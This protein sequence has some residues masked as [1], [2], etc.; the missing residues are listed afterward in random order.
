MDDNDVPRQHRA[1]RISPAARGTVAEVTIAE[2]RAPAASVAQELPRPAIRNRELDGIRGWAAIA[3]IAQHL[4]RDIFVGAFPVIDQ[5]P[6]F[7]R[8]GDLAL[9]VFFIL[10]GD[11]LSA[12]FLATGN[13]DVVRKLALTRYFRLAGMIVLSCAAVY[14]LVILGLAPHR[15]AAAAVNN[16]S[17]L[18]SALD[19]PPD[20]LGMTWYALIGVYTNLGW[21]LSGTYNPFLWTMGIE[22]VGSVLVFGY[23]A[24][25][26]RLKYPIVSTIAAMLLSALITPY[27]P[28][29]FLGILIG[30]MRRRGVF[31]RLLG[32]HR[33]QIASLVVV[34]A[35]ALYDS[36]APPTGFVLRGLMGAFLICAVASNAVLN[37][38]FTSRLSLFLGR[39]SFPLYAI[40][41]PVFISFTAAAILLAHGWGWL[42]VFGALAIIGLSFGLIVAIATAL[43]W[44][45][46]R[47][48]RGVHRLADRLLASEG[49]G[50]QPPR[51]IP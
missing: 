33:W 18:D 24:L 13:L 1:R 14:L 41:F 50:D 38:A 6:Y 8:D 23:L 28:L 40:Q 35:F 20:V 2:A 19:F 27:A 26:P 21:T 34:V 10:S 12:K 31:S 17:W 30:Y 7:F 16:S 43:E 3:V 37:R 5:T 45:E 32:D 47:Y 4:V 49:R 39:I 44:I 11:A 46:Q 9:L 22:L 29:F 42:S 51:P 48:L 36:Y 25:L 15:E